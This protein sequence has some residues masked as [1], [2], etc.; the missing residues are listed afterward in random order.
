MMV[1]FKTM[2]NELDDFLFRFAL[3]SIKIDQ[4]M[5]FARLVLGIK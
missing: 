5:Y 2:L 1:N 4:T 3:K